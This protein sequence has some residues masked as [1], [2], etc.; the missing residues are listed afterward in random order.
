MNL[1]CEYIFS[2]TLHMNIIKKNAVQTES[3]QYKALQHS[4]WS[5]NF[6][7]VCVYHIQCTGTD[8]LKQLQIYCKSSYIA[9]GT[10]LFFIIWGGGFI[11][12]GVTFG[13]FWKSLVQPKRQVSIMQ[14]TFL[15]YFTHFSFRGANSIF[16][17]L[18]EGDYV[19]D[20]T[21]L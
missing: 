14:K 6:V 7:T 17:L 19:R 9:P 5:L 16:L 20:F 13:S 2:C 18:F 4:F 21:L 1:F 3:L 8:K 12:E 11:W 10:N 15:R